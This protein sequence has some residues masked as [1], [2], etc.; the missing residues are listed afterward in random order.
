MGACK[1]SFSPN[2]P[3]LHKNYM[4][5]DLFPDDENEPDAQSARQYH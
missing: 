2:K 4:T 1:L 5:F 3:L